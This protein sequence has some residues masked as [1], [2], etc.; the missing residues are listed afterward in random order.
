MICDKFQNVHFGGYVWSFQPRIGDGSEVVKYCV[1]ELVTQ[2]PYKLPV[3]MIVWLCVCVCVCAHV[4][5]CV[6][7]VVRKTLTEQS[8][9]V[10]DCV[11]II[12]RLSL[13]FSF[14]TPLSTQ[15]FCTVLHVHIR[16]RRFI[17]VLSHDITVLIPI[18]MHASFKFKLE[19]SQTWYML[20]NSS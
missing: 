17:N 11:N 9:A 14:C 12:N 18:N 7:E 16:C 2:M 8:A 15:L 10:Y 6:L 3:Y 1:V 13:L 20:D 4:P 19:K 5:T